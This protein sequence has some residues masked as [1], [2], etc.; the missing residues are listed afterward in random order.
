MSPDYAHQHV[1][2]VLALSSTF[3]LNCNILWTPLDTT[4]NYFLTMSPSNIITL[5]IVKSVSQSHMIKINHP[6]S[7]ISSDIIQ[8]HSMINALEWKIVNHSQSLSHS[9]KVSKVIIISQHHSH[10]ILKTCYHKIK[11]KSN[12]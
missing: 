6:H 7:H 1:I 12:L 10:S 9:I 4:F 5:S 8:S 2:N 3:L 11:C